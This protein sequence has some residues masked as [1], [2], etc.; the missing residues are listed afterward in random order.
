M[1]AFRLLLR[2]LHYVGLYIQLSV[3]GRQPGHGDTG[4]Q[5]S[6]NGTSDAR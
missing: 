3:S 4:N 6:G 1:G 5:I 2:S